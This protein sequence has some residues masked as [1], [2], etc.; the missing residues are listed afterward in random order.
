MIYWF[1]GQPGHGKTN[2]ALKLAHDFKLKGRVVYVCNVRK[3]LPEKA[4][5]LPMTPEEFISWPDTLPDGAVVLCDEAY[6][7]GML[8]KRPPGAK[9]PHHVEQLAK[10]RHRGLDFIFISQSPDKQVD[11][12][13][14]DLI[15]RQVH[16]R[17][18]FGTSYLHRRE[19]DRFE[20]NPEKATPLVIA[21]TTFFKPAFDWYES[22]VEDT[23]ERKIPWYFIGFAVGVPVA[24]GLMY[25]TFGSMGK[26]LGGDDPAPTSIASKYKDGE[27]FQ[28]EV[29]EPQGDGADRRKPLTAEEY[30]AQFVPRLPTMPWSAPAYDNLKVSNQPPRVFCMQA[31]AGTDALGK[32]RAASCSCKTEQ[33]TKFVV[34]P[35]LCRTMA[36][37]GQYEPF[38][39]ERD[40]YRGDGPSQ[41]RDYQ[42]RIDRL[43][44]E[45]ATGRSGASVDG[46]AIGAAEGI[47]NGR[48]TPSTSE[49]WSTGY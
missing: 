41:S 25:Y 34:E 32:H 13:V 6:E 17:R 9:V 35:D 26:R 44:Q 23:S 48:I 20:R 8:P 22:T 3:F 5:M 47:G 36:N 24:L 33:G 49:S 31:G 43:A 30:A 46:V 18:R 4:G 45:R 40:D 37:E 19:F 10:H 11:Q 28:P 1:T 42:G 16:V 14:H 12:F 2:Q 15:E 7:H 39:Q 27:V 29:T 38:Y 21:R